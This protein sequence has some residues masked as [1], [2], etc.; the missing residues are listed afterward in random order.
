MRT[1]HRRCE[2]LRAP[3]G[4]CCACWLAVPNSCALPAGHE[5]LWRSIEAGTLRGGMA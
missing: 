5:I 1:Q 3:F 2:P 4:R